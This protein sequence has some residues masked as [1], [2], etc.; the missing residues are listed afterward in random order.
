[1]CQCGSPLR[2]MPCRS[3]SE[4]RREDGLK[5]EIIARDRAA[6]IVD[7]DGE[8]LRVPALRSPRLTGYQL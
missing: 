8:P 3:A 6:V 1:M 4:V 2:Q 5:A 7:H